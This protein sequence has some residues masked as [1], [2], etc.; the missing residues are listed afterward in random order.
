MNNIRG[1][2]IVN[3]G[4]DI[5]LNQVRDKEREIQF[6]LGLDTNSPTHI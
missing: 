1:Q 6:E 3:T 2:N 4:H 5:I